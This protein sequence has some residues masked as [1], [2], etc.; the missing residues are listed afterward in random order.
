MFLWI[1]VALIIFSIIV[2]IH[3]YGH[4]KT[5]RIFWVKVFEFGLGIPPKAK[6]LWTDKSWTEYTLNW[7]PIWWF[8]RLKWENNHYFLIYDKDKNLIN[9]KN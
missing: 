4:F 7:L 3:E 5:A 1:I 9:K 2:L 6:K 8:V